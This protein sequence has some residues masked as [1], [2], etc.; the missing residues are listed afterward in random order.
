MIKKWLSPYWKSLFS[1]IGVFLM[2]MALMRLTFF[3][4]FYQKAPLKDILKAF[5][6]GTKF[7]IRIAILLSLPFV[8]VGKWIL[9][10]KKALQGFIYFYSF[11]LFFFLLTYFLDF[12]YYA[13]LHSRINATIFGFAYNSKESLLMM[14]QSYPMVWITLGFFI[15][16]LALLFL[17][18]R[19][20]IH[21][22]SQT[23]A[24]KSR[25]T[26]RILI[27]TFL[28]FLLL[29]GLYGKWAHYPLRWSEAFFSGNSFISSLALNPIHYL[30]DSL[31]N[32][33]KEYST[34][35][36]KRYWPLIADYLELPKMQKPLDFKRPLRLT[37]LF[38]DRPNIVVIVMESY[39]SFKTSLFGNP[40]DPTPFT[41]KLLKNSYFFKNYFV[42]S[43]GTARSMFCLITGIPD[44]GALRTSSRNPLIVEQNT[45]VNTFKG[46][47]KYYFLGGSANWGNI[48]GV[49]KNN[50]PDIHIYEEGSYQRER[51]DVWGLSDLQL[52]EEVH[53]I[54]KEERKSPFFAIV[55]SS[56]FHRPYTIPEDRENFKERQVDSRELR[57]WGFES[58]KEFNSIRFADYSLGRF[59]EL[60]NNT[61]EFDNTLYFIV[62][63]HGLV[64]WGAHNLS[65]GE[66]L[67]Y[68]GR[69]HV[70]F[71][72]YSK[73]IKE[74]KEF[75]F[76]ATE[77]DVLPTIAGITGHPFTN[78]TLGR[79][80]FANYKK[81]WA[82]N[83][84]HY[85]KPPKIAGFNDT[86][87]VSWQ[88][89][90]FSPL[91][92][93]KSSHPEK[94]ITDNPN[95]YQKLKDFTYG[96]YET[97]KYLLYHNKRQKP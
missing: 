9:K 20:L 16:E 75:D 2:L 72:I 71:I 65:K 15:L 42:P 48:R 4:T 60:M 93:Y 25:K 45:L 29:L 83:Y 87:Y 50:I 58:L 28:S 18:K 35:E 95:E 57:K 22:S 80:L 82:F 62:G 47:E 69:F 6:L 31:K 14:W 32:R 56:S 68:L 59:F 77:M 73:K 81:R 52:F 70:P 92:N 51:T 1:I 86:Y 17:L 88:A 49:I 78:T 11:I 34:K 12:G 41:Q 30:F 26:Q 27:N 7:D 53:R 96:I 10:N 54:L 84:Y 44:V 33:N 37:P 13:Y 40:L 63:D 8:F 89:G 90:R 74:P 76:L 55:Q 36:T 38:T 5:Y 91:Y 19:I 24:L 39:A 64:D 67:F 66:R 23:P 79:N 97:S 3:I 46:Y 61:P 21:F 94:P 85:L 43:E